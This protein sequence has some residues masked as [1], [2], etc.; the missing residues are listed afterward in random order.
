MLNLK[1]WWKKLELGTTAVGIGLVIV[2]LKWTC[3]VVVHHDPRPLLRRN[4]IPYI[5][6]VLHAHQVAA[7][8]RSERGTGAMVSKSRD[9]TLIIPALRLSGVKPIRG[10]GIRPHSR[11]KGGLAALDAMSLHLESG[12]PVFLA[13]D[14]PGGPRG[15]VHKG[16]AV[17]AQRS[18]AAILPMIA[19]PSRR[20]TLKKAWD[21][22]Q[23]PKPFC[24]IEAYFG[25][26][27]IPEASEN[28]ETIRRR[29]EEE[30]LRLER[31][32]DPSESQYSLFE[33]GQSAVWHRRH[34]S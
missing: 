33:Q 34:V 2:V 18:Q 6:A 27:I 15:K 16:A 1:A 3:R 12:Y 11:S 23:I 13:V 21:R 10:S 31:Q 8:L 9:G 7:M 17:L 29:V 24:T 20:W 14:G 32:F 5:F 19:I 4:R 22:L 28:A 30:L 26:P 25:E